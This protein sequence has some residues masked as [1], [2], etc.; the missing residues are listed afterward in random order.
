MT[1]QARFLDC[2][3]AVA[4]RTHR[5]LQAARAADWSAFERT[6]RECRAWIERIEMMGDPNAVLDAQGRRRRFELV[7]RMLRD[8]AR[9]RDLLEPSLGRVDRCLVLRASRPAA[10]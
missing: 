3:E 5:M 2:Y 7:T 4:E 9:L 8:D 1:T 10:P 6:E